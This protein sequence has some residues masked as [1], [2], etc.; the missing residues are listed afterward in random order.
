MSAL[1]WI[2]RYAYVPFMLLGVNG[3]ALYVIISGHSYL[4]L[5]VLALFAILASFVVERILPYEKDWNNPQGDALKDTLHALVYEVSSFNA[6]VIGLPLVT[7]LVPWNGIWPTDWPFLIQVLLAIVIADIGVTLI[8][9]VSH[10]VEWLWRLHAVHHGVVRL[11]GFNGLV[12]HP[13]HHMVDLSVGTI[14]LVLAGMPF[15]VAAA[16]AF[17]S[18]VQL[19]VQ[20]SNVD[21]NLGW[22]KYMLSIGPVHRLH[23]VNWRGEGDV[24]FGLYFTF[25]DMMMGT[26]R[27]SAPQAPV[28]GDIGIDDMPNYP[29]TYLKQLI[30]PFVCDESIAEEGNKADGSQAAKGS[31][32]IMP[33]E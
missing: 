11:Y 26:F 25:W 7:F 24:N 27:L 29:Q 2:S 12:R 3:A 4:W 10:K 9:Y 20:H 8:H 32:K 5:G 1:R 6:V 28:A 23:H 14:P 30:Q 21:Y 33:A 13:L 18:S 15:E 22:F 31:S 19:L 16:L 17:T